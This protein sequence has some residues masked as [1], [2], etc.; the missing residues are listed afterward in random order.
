MD[1]CDTEWLLVLQWIRIHLPMQGTC[2]Q[3]LLWEHPNVLEQLSQ[4]ASTTEPTPETTEACWQRSCALQQEK[5]PQS[6]AYTLQGNSM[7]SNEDST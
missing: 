7:H 2:V 4:Q 3:S 5:L 1:Y 6:E